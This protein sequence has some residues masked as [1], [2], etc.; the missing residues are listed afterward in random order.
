[1]STPVPSGTLPSESGA[2]QSRRPGTSD[3]VDGVPGPSPAPS[4]PAHR[5]VSASPVPGSAEDRG[6]RRLVDP[7]LRAARV[8]P[9]H[10]RR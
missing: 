4:E 10:G 6:T 9:D 3:P 7:G 2:G 5:E 8:G 1:M